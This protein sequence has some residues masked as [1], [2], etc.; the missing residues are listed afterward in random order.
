MKRIVLMVSFAMTISTAAQAGIS[1]PILPVS[2]TFGGQVAVAC[3]VSNTSNYLRT[4]K[5]T[6][7]D[8]AAGMLAELP[9]ILGK[10]QTFELQTQMFA[11]PGDFVGVRCTVV[12]DPS[13][14]EAGIRA[15]VCSVGH[16]GGP[17]PGGV[18]QA[19][20]CLPAN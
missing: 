3:F 5:V 8:Q 7:Y 20:P 11:P 16:P 18:T 17:F 13:P 2:S 14:G 6:L 4:G 1:T 19:G 10:N 9:Y 15:S 12:G